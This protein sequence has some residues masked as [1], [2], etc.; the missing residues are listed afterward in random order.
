MVTFGLWTPYFYLARYGIENRI[1]PNLAS[2]SHWARLWGGYSVALLPIVSVTSISSRWHVL[3]LLS[4]YSV[5]LGYS[6]ARFIILSLLFG[7]SSGIVIALMM[8]YHSAHCRLPTQVRYAMS[9]AAKV[10][11]SNILTL[12]YISNEL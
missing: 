9:S 8:S 11:S 4:Y 5:G 7:A 2:C 3:A 1:A 12:A 6:T 10:T